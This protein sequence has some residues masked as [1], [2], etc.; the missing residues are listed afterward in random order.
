MLLFC[1]IVLSS[2]ILSTLNMP[3]LW[4]LLLQPILSEVHFFLA[5]DK[6]LMIA[7]TLNY[8]LIVGSLLVELFMSVLS[9]YVLVQCLSCVYLLLFLLI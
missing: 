7:A 8:S 6:R 9:A 1:L 5:S 2:D 4:R 3:V